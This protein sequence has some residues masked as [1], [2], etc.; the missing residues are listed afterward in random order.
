MYDAIEK[1]KNELSYCTNDQVTRY[2]ILN[3]SVILQVIKIG[4]QVIK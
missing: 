1:C 2:I 4:I 3:I